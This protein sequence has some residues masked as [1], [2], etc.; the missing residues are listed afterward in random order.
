MTDAHHH[1]WLSHW[2]GVLLAFC[3]GWPQTMILLISA[4]QVAV[5]T[6]VN[7]WVWLVK[8]FCFSNS[9]RGVW[10]TR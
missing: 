2:D 9:V 10:S 7:H 6:D 5:I 1:A 8:H 3:T 4:S